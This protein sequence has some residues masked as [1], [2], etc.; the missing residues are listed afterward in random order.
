MTQ[1]SQA[2]WAEAGAGLP[3]VALGWG[4]VVLLTDIGSPIDS[5]R[6]EIKDPPGA[7]TP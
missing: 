5:S 4:E 6:E 7:A 2:A 3:G 1:A